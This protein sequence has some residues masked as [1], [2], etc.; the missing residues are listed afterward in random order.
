MI[1]KNGTVALSP[2]EIAAE[3]TLYMDDD[4]RP[5]SRLPKLLNLVRCRRRPVVARWLGLHATAL[6]CSLARLLVRP[7][8]PPQVFLSDEKKRTLPEASRVFVE[9]QSEAFREF[10]RTYRSESDVI[11]R[12][13]TGMQ[14]SSTERE[15]GTFG[16]SIPGFHSTEPQT[17]S[18]PKDKVA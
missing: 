2:A 11:Y 4:N 17:V 18:D 13:Y 10:E 15:Y 8:P 5:F 1:H 14:D 7:Q 16:T 3:L 9:V 12:I 6:A